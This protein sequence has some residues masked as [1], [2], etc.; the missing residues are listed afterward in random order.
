MRFLSNY[1]DFIFESVAKN[2]MMI[3][4]SED[5]RNMLKRISDKSSI[6]QALI[7]AEESK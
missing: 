5:F 1:L 3:Y 6:E 4:Y 7:S 2:E